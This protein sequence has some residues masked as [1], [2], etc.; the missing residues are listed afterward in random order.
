MMYQRF[1]SIIR[2]QRRNLVQ[3][4]LFALAVSGAI[5][6]SIAAL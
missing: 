3:D 5:A 2:R 6:A 4:V 1:D